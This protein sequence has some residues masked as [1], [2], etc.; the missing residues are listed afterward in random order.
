ML[1]RR[2]LRAPVRP[3]STSLQRLSQVDPS[4]PD[5]ALLYKVKRPGTF[6]KEPMDPNIQLGYE[7]LYTAPMASQVS[8]TKRWS[9]GFFGVGAYI[10]YL[11]MGVGATSAVVLAGLLPLLLPLP[12]I[13][14]FAGGY[15]TR[16][17][18]VYRKDEPQTYENLTKDETLMV[19]KLSLFGRSTYGVPIRVQNTFIANR[20]LG[21]VNWVH[22]DERTGALT[23]LYV[24]DNIGGIKMDR[25]WGILEKNS[26][27]DNG[28]GFLDEMPKETSK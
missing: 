21:W 17:F 23:K 16:I 13:Q 1:V 10:G 9:L 19:E 3:F 22:L 11:T 25:I 4:D 26:N 28:R 20:R 14:Y 5:Q 27:I 6:F 24:E 2:V 8:F 7:P 12:M 15:V 18:R